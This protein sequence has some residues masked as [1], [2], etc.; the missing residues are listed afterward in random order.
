MKTEIDGTDE[1]SVGAKFYNKNFC[2]SCDKSGN[3]GVFL[4]KAFQKKSEVMGVEDERFSALARQYQDTIFRIAL[5]YFG[6]PHDAD[7]MVQEV[8][9]KLYRTETPF[10]SEAHARHWIIRVTLNQCKNTLRAPWRRFVG[11]EEWTASIPFEQREQS[12]LF[13]SVMSLPEKYRTPLYL[14]Y[15]EEFSVREIAEL[16]H[17]KE[18]AVTTRLS[19]ARQALRK[20]LTEVSPHE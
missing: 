2:E 5:N 4:V 12:D 9:L 13:L 18:S 19:R 7:D 17:V 1:K 20:E 8:L 3:C 16:L 14:F 6:N 10:E 11:L 15:F